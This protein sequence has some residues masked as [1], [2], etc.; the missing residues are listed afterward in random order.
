MQDSDDEDRRM[1][2]GAPTLVDH[3]TRLHDYAKQV[4][5]AAGRMSGGPG[6]S[7]MRGQLVREAERMQRLAAG[8]ITIGV[9]GEYSAGKSLLLG[10]LLGRPDL[11]PVSDDPTTANVT[12]LHLSQGPPSR[13][14]GIT[15][16]QVDYLSSDDL[17]DCLD[18]LLEVLSARAVTADLPSG[19]VEALRGLE[20]RDLLWP[21]L[22]SWCRTTA[23]STQDPSLTLLVR[24]LMRLRDAVLA[25]PAFIGWSTGI[26]PNDFHTALR[27]PRADTDPAVFPERHV[28]EI[29]LGV[30]PNRLEAQHLH[31]TLPIV[32]RVTL[33]VQVPPGVWDL[34]GLRG[35]NQLVLLDFPGLNSTISGVRDR[36]LSRRE[37]AHVTTIFILL[38]AFTAGSDGPTAFPAMMRRPREELRDSVLVGLGRFDQLPN[39]ISP[40]LYDDSGADRVTDRVLTDGVLSTLMSNARL[41]VGTDHNERVAFHSA[42]VGIHSLDESTPGLTNYD[43]GFADERRLAEH[44]PR[45]LA[46]ADKWRRIAARLSVDDPASGLRHALAE[47]A[48]DGGVR[49]IRNRLEQHVHE[50]GLTLRHAQLERLADSVDQQRLD[51]V[52]AVRAGADPDTTRRAARGPIEGLLESV[53]QQLTALEERVPLEIADPR[54]IRLPNG[55]PL[56]AAIEQRAVETVFAWP[57]WSALFEAV[58]GGVVT[59]QEVDPDEFLFPGQDA[60]STSELPESTTEFADR[61]AETVAACE[62]FAVDQAWAAFRDWIRRANVGLEPAR[63]TRRVVVDNDA[64]QR[65]AE[66]F[67]ARGFPQAL[68]AALDLGWLPDHIR[69]RVQKKV[70]SLWAAQPADP[71]AAFPLRS[72]TGF[73]W[74][75][76]APASVQDSPVATLARHQIRPA[77]LRREL[78]NGVVDVVLG[79]LGLLQIEISRATRSTLNSGR[80]SLANSTEFID[81]VIGTPATADTD[82]A[83]ELAAIGRPVC[84]SGQG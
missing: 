65:I 52:D 48:A 68:A 58:Q 74:S 23:W 32:E 36:Y 12:A 4:R 70:G 27:L 38:N 33:G 46:E 82:P 14:A 13:P 6:A 45:A 64:E 9:V 61:F 1:P 50:H 26:A 80:R 75:A 7:E 29:D 60:M 43:A 77:R 76:H 16:A 55:T 72:D 54:R 49:L 21:A 56:A 47:F 37:L 17:D 22:E 11:L 40:Q 18:H 83:A 67:E 41:L 3:I 19:P 42:M 5:L 79:R 71:A 8:P 73:V 59:A 31:A 78:V 39:L 57:E 44:V 24:E 66:R 51:L 30:R 28:P 34:S 69:P 62:Q 53:R 25:A 63:S 81:A 2:D 35:N 15:T 10:L 20:S 84:P